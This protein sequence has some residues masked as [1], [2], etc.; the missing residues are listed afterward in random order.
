MHKVEGA[1]DAATD[2]F[3]P[4]LEDLSDRLEL[5]EAE[6]FERPDPATLERVFGIRRHLLSARRAIWPMREVVGGLERS[7]NELIQKSTGIFL[8]DLYDHTIQVA[9][10]VESFRD[11]VS[12]LQDLYLSSISNKMNEVMKVLTIIAT[13]FIPLTFVAGIYGMN[14]EHMP[15][16]KWGW[17]YPAA[18]GVMGIVALG[19]VLYFRRKKWL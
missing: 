7:E 5:I 1:L 9:D 14:F 8:R 12:G 6:V 3:F 11:M 15:E 4:V 13:I 17:A 2:A 18:L 16:L 10:A 19:M